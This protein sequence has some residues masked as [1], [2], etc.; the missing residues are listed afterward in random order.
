MQLAREEG[1][2]MK[3]FLAAAA[4]TASLVTFSGSR[5]EAQEVRPPAA[6]GPTRQIVGGAM[7]A[8][9]YVPSFIVAAES[10]R[11]GDHALYAPVVGP[12]IDLGVRGGCGPVSCTTEGLYKTLLVADGVVQG[13]GLLAVVIPTAARTPVL[14]IAGARITPA[15]ISRDGYGI[16]AVGEF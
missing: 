12:W 16:S 11:K 7:L 2:A 9:A 4:V 15:R 3:R 5:A 6:A 10:G 13:L 14:T 1:D 8:G